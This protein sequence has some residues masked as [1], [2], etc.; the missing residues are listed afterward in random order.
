M[1][2]E[3]EITAGPAAVEGLGAEGETLLERPKGN[4]QFELLSKLGGSF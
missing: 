3:R 2:E 4:I 1:M